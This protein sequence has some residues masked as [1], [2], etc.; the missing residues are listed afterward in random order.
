MTA[1]KILVTIMDRRGIA[2]SHPGL[3]LNRY[4]EK[5]AA[6]EN[7]K[8]EYKQQILQAAIKAAENKQV[9]ELYESAF[10]RWKSELDQ[11]EQV[12]SITLKTIG[13]LI[14]GLGTENVLETGIR[15]HHTYGMPIIPGSAL[16]GLAA[17][18]C[19][20]IWGEPGKTEDI[21]NDS[22]KFRGPRK[23]RKGQRDGDNLPAESQ[24]DIHKFLFGDT[25][26]SGCIT[27]HDAWMVPDQQQS[28]LKLDVMTP[29]HPDW[30][31]L[32]NPAPPTDFDSPTPVPFL[33]VE[34]GFLVTVSWCGPEIEGKS[35]WCKLAA[36]CLCNALFD[37]GIGGKTSS[38][39]GL[40]DLELFAQDKEK[41]EIQRRNQEEKDKKEKATASMTAIEQQMQKVIDEYP[42]Q[43]AS[44]HI[45]LIKELEKEN[46]RWTNNEDR[47]EVANRIKDEMT[48]ANV[49]GKKGK[50]LDRT[51]FIKKILGENETLP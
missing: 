16:K 48:K 47:I 4:L 7:G 9:R 23:Q 10:M 33:S 24:G 31:N 2:D 32:E 15:L 20:Q 6:G 38:G 1:R 14:V 37:W 22:L 3:L 12:E 36:D 25:E 40:F 46:G 39:Y 44:V 5:S 50:D 43:K 51:N 27:F 35:K 34:G 21:N 13:R 30:N 49:W 42:D 29:H 18:Y 17:H 19:D 8:P 45:R 11:M 28:P 26:E 41:A